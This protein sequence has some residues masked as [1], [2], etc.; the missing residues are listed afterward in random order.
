M[1]T[2]AAMAETGRHLPGVC[3][4]ILD[5]NCMAIAEWFATTTALFHFRSQLLDGIGKKSFPKK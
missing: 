4:R 1:E 5:H 3:R 2:T